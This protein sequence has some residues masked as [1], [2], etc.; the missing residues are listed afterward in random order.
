MTVAWRAR[1]L[2]APLLLLTLV[3]RTSKA[4]TLGQTRLTPSPS[5]PPTQTAGATTSTTQSR[6][7]RSGSS[8]HAPA[9][10]WRICLRRQKLRAGCF[11]SWAAASPSTALRLWPQQRQGVCS[12]QKTT[13]ERPGTQC[14]RPTGAHGPCAPSPP[15]PAVPALLLTL[16]LPALLLPLA[17]TVL[18]K[19]AVTTSR[20]TRLRSSHPMRPWTRCR[21]TRS[22]R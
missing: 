16:T 4:R 6:S 22:G 13:S 18:E 11:I 3:K 12:L 14:C 10:K 5:S 21:C 15:L 7:R 20:T 1:R 8:C 17:L 2:P 19:V 9:S